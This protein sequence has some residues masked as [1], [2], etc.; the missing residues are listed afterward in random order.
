MNR[1]RIEPDSLRCG[2]RQGSPLRCDRF[3]ARR[4]RTR[5]ASLTGVL[6]SAGRLCKAVQAPPSSPKKAA[7]LEGGGPNG[8]IKVGRVERSLVGQMR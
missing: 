5:A 8:T 7:P 6:A 2:A 4:S 1:D 3:A